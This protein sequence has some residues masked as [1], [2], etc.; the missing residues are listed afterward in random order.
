MKSS[1]KPAL[2]RIGIRRVAIVVASLALLGTPRPASP[3][4]DTRWRAAYFPTVRLARHEGKPVRFFDD[5]I[6]GKSVAIDPIYTPCRY[7]CP[8]ETAR[9]AQVQRLLGPRMGREVFFY[10]ITIDP[11]HDTPAVL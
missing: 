2:G 11:A 4:G 8:L 5:L 10:S 6:K 9:L 7:A 1:R 3:S